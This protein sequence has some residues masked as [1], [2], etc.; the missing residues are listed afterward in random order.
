MPSTTNA[1]LLQAN[2][3]YNL[4]G[5]SSITWAISEEWPTYYSG[6]S[7]SLYSESNYNSTAWYFAS[8]IGQAFSLIGEVVGKSVTEEGV[9]DAA[10][11]INM[12]SATGTG[13]PVAR[14][15]SRVGG[16]GDDPA[17]RHDIWLF[18]GINGWAVEGPDPVARVRMLILHEA[19]HSLGMRHSHV[20]NEDSDDVSDPANS[21]FDHSQSWKYTV[22]SYVPSPAT[23]LSSTVPTTLQLYDIWALQGLYGVDT[24]TRNGSGTVYGTGTVFNAGSSTP[25]L[26]TIW[27]AGGDHD[28]FDASGSSTSAVIDLR[29]GEFSSVGS[30][31]SLSSPLENIAIAWRTVIEDARGTSQ[32]DVIIGNIYDN[33]IEGRAGDDLIFG[34]GDEYGARKT[35][36]FTAAGLNLS[37]FEQGDKTGSGENWIS[38]G[39]SGTTRPNQNDSGD[40]TIYGGDGADRIYGGRG[41]DYL[42]GEGGNDF[43]YGGAEDDRLVG[44]GD[45]DHLDGGTGNDHLLGGGGNDVIDGGD[46]TDTLDFALAGVGAFVTL[47]ALI[48]PEGDPRPRFQLA[49]VGGADTIVSVETIR[50][51]NHSD[52]IGIAGSL[53]ALRPNNISIDL[54]GS[55]TGIHQ[56]IVD[57]SQLN[58]G[59]YIDLGSGKVSAL[60]QDTATGYWGWVG[61]RMIAPFRRTDISIVNGNE[62]VGTQY[63]DFLIGSS[64]DEEDG[65]GFSTLIGG[66]GNDLLMA[67]GWHTRMIGGA[68]ADQFAVGASTRIDDAGKGT[69]DIVTYCGIRLYGG[70]NQWWMSDSTAYWAPFTTL[71]TMF[72]VIGSELLYTAAFFVDIPFMKFAAYQKQADGSLYMNLGWGHGGGA[73]LVDYDYDLNS[74]VGS[75]GIS[76]FATENEDDGGPNLRENG[77][78]QFI[79]LALYAG[80]GVGLPGFDPLVLDLDGDGFELDHG[81]SEQ[82]LFRV[83][84]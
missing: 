80:F 33:I 10:I 40:D 52:T 55:G 22:M 17:I 57:G 46:G 19:L 47:S 13:I 41:E 58:T 77:F 68:G 35:E 59:V 23:G 24:Q 64:G 6:V 79:N 32:R 12:S 81:I 9:G 7:S 76:V 71:L 15:L 44:G 56:D 66:G 3:V 39:A 49:E 37:L 51:T 31:N 60:D 53:T 45:A 2:F 82:D 78:T 30:T 61:E 75:G 4:S 74:G 28:L 65:E 16:E 83:R 21:L 63:S 27:D 20:Q 5:A 43:L 42:D 62:A 1:S 8:P 26:A 29:Q 48:S 36:A 25:V 69:G 72:P 54:R 34:D 67:A 38:D 70:V 11:V 84:Q 18:P 14:S 73:A 50:G